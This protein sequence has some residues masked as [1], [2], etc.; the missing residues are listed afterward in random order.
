[1]FFA[2]IL[3]GM[4]AGIVM[5]VVQH[6]RVTPYILA[7]EVVEQQSHDPSGSPTQAWSPQDG[8]ERLAYTALANLIVSVAFALTLIGAS[9]LLGLPITPANGVLWGLS[10]FLTFSL[11]PAAGLPPEL[12]G[13]VGAD[14]LN[15]QLW[16]WFAAGMT[17]LALVLF[18]R[19][20]NNIYLGISAALVVLPHLIGSPDAPAHASEVPAHLASGFTA[21][22]LAA[23]AVF[24]IVLGLS[25]GL[26][27]QSAS[28]EPP[29][30]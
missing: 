3:A 1:M 11:A 12:P 17:A 22:A 30:R 21:N 25:L 9:L 10:G 4:A 16:W 15:R 14:L 8:I 26:L 2:A 19:R 18:A 6:L 29:T 5:S 23:A 7:A 20:P 24:W 28:R 27:I 13:M